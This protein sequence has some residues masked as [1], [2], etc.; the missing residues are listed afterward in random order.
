MATGVAPAA[1]AAAA[2]AMLEV[3]F[4][5]EVG[6]SVGV[7]PVIDRPCCSVLVVPRAVRI[8]PER[9]LADSPPPKEGSDELT[10]VAVAVAVAVGVAVAVAVGVA[11]GVGGVVDCGNRK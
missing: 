9:R 11:M 1:A 5:A 8:G 3:E 2:A 10:A 7:S 6:V 4:E